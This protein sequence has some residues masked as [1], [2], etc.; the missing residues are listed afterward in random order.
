[1]VNALSS[2]E[3]QPG[4]V[5]RPQ[6]PPSVEIQRD[7]ENQN[8]AEVNVA[9]VVSVKNAKKRPLMDI[10]RENQEAYN[11]FITEKMPKVLRAIGVSSDDDS[12]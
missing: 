12:E 5:P 6:S 11:K 4:Q 8:L 10:I 1:M 3:H 2:E 7:N 9:P